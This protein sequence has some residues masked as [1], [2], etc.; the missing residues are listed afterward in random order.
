MLHVFLISTLDRGELLVS[1][2]CNF[3]RQNS[4]AYLVGGLK[5]WA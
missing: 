3:A 4:P 2:R 1:H 5:L